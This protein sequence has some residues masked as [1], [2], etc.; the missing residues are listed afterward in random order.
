MAHLLQQLLTSAAEKGEREQAW[1]EKD[2][3]Y[4]LLCSRSSQPQVSVLLGISGVL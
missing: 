4:H 2:D 1:G 3:V